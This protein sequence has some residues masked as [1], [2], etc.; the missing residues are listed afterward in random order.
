MQIVHINGVKDKKKN[1]HLK[2][3][4][5][6]NF[7]DTKKCFAQNEMLP[8]KYIHWIVELSGSTP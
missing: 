8:L 3:K 7:A 4:F 1:N 6:L 5:K 2:R